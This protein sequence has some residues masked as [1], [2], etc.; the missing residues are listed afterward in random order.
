MKDITLL[1]RLRSGHGL[2]GHQRGGL[3]T[4]CEKCGQHFVRSK[5]NKTCTGL[6]VLV[7]YKM[8]ENRNKIVENEELSL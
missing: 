6:I 5:L 3:F 7:E 2:T 8:K 1:E 4:M